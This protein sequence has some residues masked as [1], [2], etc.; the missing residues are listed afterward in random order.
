M[1]NTAAIAPLAKTARGTFRS[2]DLVSAT[3]QV[4]ASNAGAANPIR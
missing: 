2:G 1:K 4:A 3:W